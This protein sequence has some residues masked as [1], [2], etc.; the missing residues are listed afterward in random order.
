MDNNKKRER[1]RK[2]YDYN[3][4]DSDDKLVDDP[5]LENNN[6]DEIF[7]NNDS[8]PKKKLKNEIKENNKRLK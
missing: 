8:L 7:I 1:L 2:L 5:L 6:K 4:Y 3:S